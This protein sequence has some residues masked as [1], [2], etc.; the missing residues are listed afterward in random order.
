MSSARSLPVFQENS[1]IVKVQAVCSSETTVST[2]Q[3]RRCHNPEIHNVTIHGKKSLILF[4]LG[5]S[6]VRTIPY[7]SAFP[8]IIKQHVFSIE[9]CG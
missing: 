5:K 6:D 1:S 2:Y 3:T 4:S 8:P 9:L 7:S